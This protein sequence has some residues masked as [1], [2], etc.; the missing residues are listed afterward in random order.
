MIGEAV[1]LSSLSTFMPK[2]HATSEGRCT[3][4]LFATYA[5]FLAVAEVVTIR[6]NW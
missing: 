4:F 2:L 6:A 5:L 3:A 1:V